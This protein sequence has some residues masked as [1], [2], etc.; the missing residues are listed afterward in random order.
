[1]VEP[2]V[3]LR[4]AVTMLV[5]LTVGM[6]VSAA[7]I[8]LCYGCCYAIECLACWLRRVRGRAS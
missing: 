7:S 4:P 8:L 3:I 1:M 6:A 2:S 5:V